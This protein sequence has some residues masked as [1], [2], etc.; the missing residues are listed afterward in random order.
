MEVKLMMVVTELVVLQEM[1]QAVIKVLQ[2]WLVV[3]VKLLNLVDMV[4]MVL[5]VL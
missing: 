2:E 5:Q 3:R 4:V 1:L